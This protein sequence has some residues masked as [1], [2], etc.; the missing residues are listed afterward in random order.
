M[1]LIV[2]ILCRDGVVL[3]SDSAATFGSAGRPTIGQQEMRK[4]RRIND[5]LLYTSTG[6]VGISQLIADKL[7]SLWEGKIFSGSQSPE[8]VMD[9]IGKEIVQ[10]VGPYLQTANL[11]RSLVGDASSSL[12]KSLVAMPVNQKSCL[13]NFDVNGAPERSTPDLPFIAL[14]SGQPIADPFLAFLRRLLWSDRE[15][16]LAEG[17]L[18]AV[19][20]IE[21]V[22]RTNPGGVGGSVQLATLA[23][24]AGKTPTV[25][26]VS[27]EDI[28][29]HLQRVVSAE[30]SLVS[31]LR[32]TSMALADAGLLT[33]PH[34]ESA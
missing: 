22:G 30:Q 13:F 32:G 17:R 20:T 1:T 23:P 25:S 29:E 27:E 11:Q 14:G 2:G 5:H 28:Q 18:A 8:N 4:L 16:T 12:C 3:A 24:S 9:K 15:P 10:L 21:H 26:E 7:K 31:E 6:A 34:L 19:W 33:P